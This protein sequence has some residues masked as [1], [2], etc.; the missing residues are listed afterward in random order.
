MF[1]I[2]NYEKCIFKHNFLRNIIFKVHYKENIC[3]TSKRSDFIETFKE[4]FPIVSD[5]IA[6][7]I[8]FTLG[9]QN[10]KEQSVSV[11]DD[12]NA[13]QVIMRSINAQKEL[14]L[15]NELL[16]YKETG[17][18][19]SSSNDFNS[20]INQGIAFLKENGTTECKAFSLRK[21]NIVD[22]VS[23]NMEN[24]EVS[25]YDPLRE[26]IAPY[27]LCMYEDFRSSNKFI[28]QNIYTIQ[29]E[30]NDYF[31]TIKYGYIISEKN[32]SSSNIKGQ[33]VIDLSLE[34]K[35]SCSIDI[36]L[37]EELQKCHQEL[38]NA[39]RWCIS[40][41]MFNMINEE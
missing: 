31:L 1:G 27:L 29:F 8:S 13:H 6:Q 39:F 20:K 38:Y 37:S 30:E 25:T 15:N 10:G 34:K 3:C 11:K 22:F 4:D 5:G 2:N 26:L 36:L 41:K 7:A 21:I 14:T 40:P 16:Q 33:I 23:N 24:E 12:S 17:L 18:T 28:K 19:Y 9:G 32:A 35:S